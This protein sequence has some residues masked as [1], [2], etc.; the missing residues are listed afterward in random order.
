MRRLYSTFAHG[1]PGLGLL[2]MRLVAGVALVSEAAMSIVGGASAGAAI[3]RVLAAILGMLLIVGL[4]TPIAGV[5]VALLALRQAFAQPANPWS[6]IL[7]GTIGI[8]LVL[9][10]PGGWSVDAR[11][12]GWRRIDFRDRGK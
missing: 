2:L 3:T 12:F 4:W 10:G 9:L 11:L 7:L 1:L 5:F 8:A 6:C